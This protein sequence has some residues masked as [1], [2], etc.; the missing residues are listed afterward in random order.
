MSTLTCSQCQAI[1]ELSDHF[2]E[3]CG[4]PLYA[5]PRET[6]SDRPD[7]RASPHSI[8]VILQN[9]TRFKLNDATD[10]WVGRADPANGWH[11]EIDLSGHAGLQG[12]VSRKHG[13]FRIEGDQ[14]YFEDEGSSN[15]TCLNGVLLSVGKRFPVYSG[16]ELLFGRIYAR[17]NIDE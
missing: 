1:C 15:G 9:G 4:Q 5:M 8:V 17:V 6:V 2:C 16:D 3:F 12:G 7:D 11:P 10:F 13:R 14:L